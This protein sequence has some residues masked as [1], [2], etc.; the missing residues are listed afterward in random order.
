MF[1]SRA[2]MRKTLLLFALCLAGALVAV[3]AGVVVK[4]ACP[5]GIL[6]DYASLLVSTACMFGL[7]LVA[8]PRI[9]GPA[10]LAFAPRRADGRA[11]AMRLLALGALCWACCLLPVEQLFAFSRGVPF[12]D[13]LRPIQ[14]SLLELQRAND[15]YMAHLTLPRGPGY[16]AAMLLAMA[17]APAVFEECFFRGVLQQI[18]ARSSR[19]FWT[20]VV[21]TAVV[22]SIFHFDFYGFLPRV[23]LGV[24]LGVAYAAAGRLWLPVALHFLNNAASVVLAGAVGADVELGDLV[25]SPAVYYALLALSVAGAFASLRWLARRRA[26]VG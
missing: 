5:A 2:A 12:P 19:G 23:L 22:F 21:A 24:M 20:P 17:V 18:L 7:P 6:A 3:A 15:A 9:L 13:A 16:T 25:A 26:S 4:L 1:D 11:G 10:A 14:E 8:A